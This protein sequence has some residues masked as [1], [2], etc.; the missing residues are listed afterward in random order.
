MG[1]FRRALI[2]RSPVIFDDAVQHLIE[3]LAVVP[4]RSPQQALLGRSDLQQGSAA[5]SVP[6]RRARFQA[7]HAECLERELEDE[8]RALF[9][10]ARAPERRA[11]GETPLGR[12][13]SW[14][15]QPATASPNAIQSRSGPRIDVDGLTKIDSPRK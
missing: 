5:P 7:M 11:D 8:P 15:E 13:E 3:V 12:A 4:E 9:E 14:L 2:T 1:R 6:D 10:Y